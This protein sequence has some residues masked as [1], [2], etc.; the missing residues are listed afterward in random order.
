MERLQAISTVIL[1]GISITAEAPNELE[2]ISRNFNLKFFKEYEFMKVLQFVPLRKIQQY[3]ALRHELPSEIL[4]INNP[5]ILF[6]HQSFNLPPF[7]I[8]YAEL[9][10]QTI[11]WK[12]FAAY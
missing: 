9:R 11:L 10:R 3:L 4:E 1:I 8:Y 12:A 2:I 7:R 5:F 6:Y